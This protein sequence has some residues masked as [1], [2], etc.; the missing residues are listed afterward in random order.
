MAERGYRIGNL[1]VTLILETPK[2]KDIKA[3]MK[4]NIVQL[5]H[6]SPDRVNIKARTH[7]KVHSSLN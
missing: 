2:M 1:D 3:Q 6:T 7:E 4:E 5:L